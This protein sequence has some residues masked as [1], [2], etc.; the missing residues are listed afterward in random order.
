MQSMAFTSISR[1]CSFQANI[2]APVRFRALYHQWAPGW[3]D[4]LVV[5]ACNARA[6]YAPL[7]ENK[8]PV[9][10]PDG[11]WGAHEWTRFPQFYDASAPYLAYIPIPTSRNPTSILFRSV[12]RMDWTIPVEAPAKTDLRVP[13]PGLLSQVSSKYQWAK[14]LVDDDF[15]AFIAKKPLGNISPSLHAWEHAWDSYLTLVSGAKGYRDFV[16][17]MRSFQQGILELIAFRDWMADMGLTP[18]TGKTGD[19][20]EMD[21]RGSYVYSL[22]HYQMFAKFGVASFFVTR[23]S[24]WVLDDGRR[25]D[26]CALPGLPNP[27]SNTSTVRMH[28]KPI[29]HYPPHVDNVR[30]FESAARGVAT[31]KDELIPMPVFKKQIQK[32]GAEYQL[33]I[34][35]H[36]SSVFIPECRNAVD[37]AQNRAK[38][39]QSTSPHP[40]YVREPVKIYLMVLN[41]LNWTK[42]GVCPP[43]RLFPFPPIHL[44]WGPEIEEKVQTYYFHYLAIR[45]HVE[46]RWDA[47]NPGLTTQD[48]RAVL[49]DVAWK[50]AWP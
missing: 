35:R 45:D 34:G 9:I 29:W 12:S 13:V 10:E 40:P 17:L 24:E 46:W 6:I 11:L 19:H 26:L 14:Q 36:P 50:M 41:K 20:S 5:V 47:G 4:D 31:R 16:K 32:H 8:A 37:V 43:G 48:W 21:T 28:N 25:R 42:I 44:F 30:D 1:L 18:R 38:M 39:F 33:R 27:T 22:E 49:S 7:M 3:E 23:T 15:T 2:M